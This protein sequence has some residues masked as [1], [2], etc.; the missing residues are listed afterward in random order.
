MGHG[1]EIGIIPRF[2]EELFSRAEV[3]KD[4]NKVSRSNV[5]PASFLITIFLKMFLQ[6]E[7]L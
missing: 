6:A 3:A 4:L 7:K 2:C 5:G 1:N